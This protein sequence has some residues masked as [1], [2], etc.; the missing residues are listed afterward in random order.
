[1]EDWL[2]IAE[3]LPLGKRIYVDCTCGRG[4][5]LVINH[6]NEGYSTF[7]FR[8]DRKDWHY[9]GLL[10]IAQIEAM[11][12]LNEQAKTYVSKIELPKD[13]TTD[14]PIEGRLWLYKASITESLIKK[15]KIGYSE[16][17]R[18]V[19]LPLY[20]YNKLIW[21]IGR[22][23]HIGQEPKYIAPSESRDAVMFQSGKLGSNVVVTEDILSAI[24]VGELVSAVSLLGTKMTIE[25]LDVLSNH[26][27]FLWMDNDS[28][29][30]NAT[31][32]IERELSMVTDVV[33]IHTDHDPKQYTRNEMRDILKE[34]L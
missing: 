19:I 25:Q 12:V 15:Y 23:V 7:C 14:I 22:A 9:K 29:G 24:R 13:F 31:K 21:F 2:E 10:S 27:V 11:K 32:K 28:A 4:K 20:R 34:A 1:M 17:L 8:C 18:R 16:E 33:R 5:T 30:W 26:K 6:R 3:K